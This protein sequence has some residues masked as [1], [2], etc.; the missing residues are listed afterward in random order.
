[1]CRPEMTTPHDPSDRAAR[2]ADVRHRLQARPDRG[3]G[4][5]RGQAEADRKLRAVGT[6]LAQVVEELLEDGRHVSVLEI[7]FGWG[8]ALIELALRFR[9][10]PVSFSGINVEHQPP[11][12]R[13]E[14]LGIVAEALE[15]APAGDIEDMRWPDVHFYDATTLHFGDETLDFVYSVVSIRFIEDKVRVIEEVARALRPGGRALLDIGERGWEYPA[16]PASDPRLLTP[17]PARIVLHRDLVLVALADYLS[18]AAAERYSISLP[19][20]RR[21]VV[22]L[23]KHASGP[24][25]L[26]LSLDR[27]RTIRMREF[28]HPGKPAGAGGI[29]SAYEVTEPRMAA[30]RAQRGTGYRTSGRPGPAPHGRLPAP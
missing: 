14:D 17:H 9:S 16:G 28:P 15:L 24:L 11:V 20:G 30:Y 8:A 10:R 23:T 12:L 29:R 6:P 5:T 25:D 26:G 13:A 4:R 18:W 21:C 1:M 22:D 7:G 3:M 2:V 19:P 27:E